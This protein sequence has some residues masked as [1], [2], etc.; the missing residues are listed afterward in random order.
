MKYDWNFNLMSI[1]H[2][3]HNTAGEMKGAVSSDNLV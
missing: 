3:V 2:E 1:N